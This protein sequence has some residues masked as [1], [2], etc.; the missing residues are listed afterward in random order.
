MRRQESTMNAMDVMVRNI[1]TVKPDDDVTDVIKLLTEHDISALPVVDD[2]GAVIGVISE[3]DLIRREEIGTEKHRPWWLEALT[4]ASILAEEFAKS[5]GRRVAEIMSANI[6]SA[7]EDTPL[8]EI[9]ALLE[10][11]RIKRV[12]I[13]RD[14]KLVGIVSQSNLVQALASSQPQPGASAESDREIRLELLNRLSKQDWTDFGSRNVIVSDG[15]VHLWGLVG[16][17]E[18]HKAL[19]ALA[20]EASGVVRVADEMIPAY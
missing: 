13:L 5:H 10:K 12:P 9:A 19:I 20:E 6:V 8:E 18:E 14:G 16:S 4:P 2:E 17:P 11:H 7:S 1:V 3:A 15:V